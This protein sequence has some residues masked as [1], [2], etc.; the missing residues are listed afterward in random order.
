LCKGSRYSRQQDKQRGA[1][2]HNSQIIAI[3]STNPQSAYRFPIHD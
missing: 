3:I 2:V 1:A